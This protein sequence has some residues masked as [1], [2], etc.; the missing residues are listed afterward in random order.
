MKQG[1]TTTFPIAQMP[2]ADIRSR[3]YFLGS[4]FSE[5]MADMLGSLGF[6]SHGN[7]FGIL[8]NPHSLA[9]CL[10][11][12]ATAYRYSAQDLYF[13]NGDFVSLE[14]HGAF[15][16][17][18]AERLISRLNEAS[19]QAHRQISEANLVVITLGT[20]WVWIFRDPVKIVGNCHR[21]PGHEF[22]RR[23][24]SEKE[25][26]NALFKMIQYLR[27][28]KPDVR[29]ILTVSPVR[30]LREGLVQNSASKARLVSAA[31]A[32]TEEHP[33]LLY[34][35]SF[36]IFNDELRDHR[37]FAEDL[38]HPSPW[39]I[40]YIFERFAETCFDDR[41]RQYMAQAIRYAR[42]KSHRLHTADPQ[43]AAAWEDKKK[44]ALAALKNEFPE[45]SEW[46]G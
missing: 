35:P 15:R 41:A 9:N 27:M 21:I 3:W 44:Q 20:A 5:H 23:L 28:I 16:D 26:R 8:Y 17:A 45:I 40:R 24:L 39:S 11:R 29:I 2:V 22:T 34:F 14:H 43:A 10:E 1:L 13:T 36:E 7:P 42:M 12:I 4:C 38:A 31:A 46:A 33:D 37:F 30:H 19:E 6:S 32:I 25:V 18:N